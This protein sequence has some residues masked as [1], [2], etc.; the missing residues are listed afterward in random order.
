MLITL[1]KDFAIAHDGINITEYKAGVE[2]DVA[3]TRANRLRELGLLTEAKMS[4]PVQE[5]KSLEAKPLIKKR[6]R[7]KKVENET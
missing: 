5:N 3:E 2:Y 6:G 1:N 7:K 4:N